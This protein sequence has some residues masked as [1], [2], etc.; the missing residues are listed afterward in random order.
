L[1]DATPPTYVPNSLVDDAVNLV[2]SSYGSTHSLVMFAKRLDGLAR[3]AVAEA[4]RLDGLE[5]P[6]LDK[7][8]RANKPTFRP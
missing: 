3:A 1:G 6:A 2:R 7:A 5:A 4:A 8:R